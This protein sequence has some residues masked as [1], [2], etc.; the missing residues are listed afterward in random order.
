MDSL[1]P[2]WSPDGKLLVFTRLGGPDKCYFRFRN[3]ETG[4]ETDVPDS[5]YIAD[6]VGQS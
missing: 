3:L 2:N 1:D 6:T 4:E 5:T